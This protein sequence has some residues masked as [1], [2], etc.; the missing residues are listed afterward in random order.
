MSTSVRQIEDRIWRTLNYSRL[1]HILRSVTGEPSVIV[2]SLWMDMLSAVPTWEVILLTLLTTAGPANLVNGVNHC[3]S[4]WTIFLPYSVS[5][6][7]FWIPFDYQLILFL[8]ST[9]EDAQ[10]HLL[11]EH[12]MSITHVGF[13]QFCY[14]C[15]SWYVFTIKVVSRD[16]KCL[17]YTGSVTKTIGHAIW[18]VTSLSGLNRLEKLPT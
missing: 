5:P 13:L 8:S 9:N 7:K 14:F 3:T 15:Y 16:L 1:T 10:Q 11:E 4:L 18:P 6:F 2:R 12:I 17:P